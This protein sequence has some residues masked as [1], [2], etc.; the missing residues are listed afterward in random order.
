MTHVEYHGVTDKSEGG[1]GGEY[2][3]IGDESST[4]RLRTHVSK[5][6]TR[7]L[8]RFRRAQNARIVG[9]PMTGTES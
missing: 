3:H 5:M 4:I 1:L 9:V 7:E 2:L 8:L 6:S